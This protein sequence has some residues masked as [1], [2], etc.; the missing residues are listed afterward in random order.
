MFHNYITFK[1][2]QNIKIIGG[3]MQHGDY[4]LKK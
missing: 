3:N 2:K 4:S 1:Q